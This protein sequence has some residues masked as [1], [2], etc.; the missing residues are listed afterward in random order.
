MSLKLRKFA[1]KSLEVS[2]SVEKEKG[3]GTATAQLWD[4]SQI[5]ALDK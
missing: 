2:I 1:L 5:K 4:E 3:K